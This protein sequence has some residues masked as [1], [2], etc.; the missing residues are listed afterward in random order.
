MNAIQTSMLVLFVGGCAAVGAPKELG[1]ARSAERQ[2]S[3]GVTAQ[4]NPAEL[5]TAKMSLKGAEQS[6]RDNGDTQETRDL[7]YAAGLRFRTADSRA[8][9][10]DTDRQRLRAMAQMQAGIAANGQRTSAELDRANARLTTQGHALQN[11]QHR[12]ADAEKRA[13]QAAA[14][15]AALGAVRQEPRGMVLTLSGSVL[16]TSAK[17]ELLPSARAK[18]NQVADTLIKQDPNSKI[19]VEG[20]TDSQGTTPYNQELSQRRA[21]AVRDYLVTRGIASD[22]VTSQGYGLTRPVADNFSA[23][24]RANNRRVEIVVQ[25]SANP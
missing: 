20:F 16:F 19:V 7:A 15:L 17:A 2:S 9:T 6:F 18:L 12:R 5:H 24:G 23:E 25:P 10:M 21:Q 3:Q 13:A 14:D 1:D 22:R 11:E 8:R 4:L